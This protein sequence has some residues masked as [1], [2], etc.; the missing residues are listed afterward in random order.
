MTQPKWRTDCQ[1]WWERL[2]E[3]RSIVPPPIFPEEAARALEVFD[4]LKIVDAPGS[5]T[6]GEAAMP[7]VRDIVASIFGSYD[8]STGRRLIKE[9]LLVVPK[10]SSKSTIAS[11]IMMTALILNERLSAEGTIIAPTVEVATNAFKPAKDMVAHD[12]DLTEMMT[13][14]HHL[15]LITNKD[16]GAQLK[17]VAASADTLGGKKSSYILIDE[18]WLMGKMNDAV[19]MFSEA[20]G[21]LASRP[22]GFVVYLTTQS[23][24]PPAGVFKQKLEYARGVRDGTVDDPQFVPIIYEFPNDFISAGKHLDPA[25]FKI[26]NPNYGVSVDQDFLEREFR[27]AKEAGPDVLKV[28]TAK[29]LNV[30]VG[31]RLRANRWLGADFWLQTESQSVTLDSILERSEVVTV[32]GD[33]GGLD[34][35]LGLTLCGRDRDTKKK[36]IWSHAWAHPSVL[37][38]H[39]QFEAQIRDYAKRGEVTLV[40]RVG[41]DVLEFAAIVKRVF[42]AG[43]LYKVGLDPAGVG[44][45]LE[46]LSDAEI[47]EDQITGVSQGWRLG[48]AIKTAERWLAAGEIEHARQPLMNWCVGNAMVEPKGNAILITKAAS[49]GAK[50]DPVMSM[51]NSIE[52]MAH[53]PAAA[54]SRDMEEFFRNPIIAL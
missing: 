12:E 44:A 42:D 9:W 47:P 39:K 8:R 17:I 46:A 20:M 29:H 26:V 6:F 4:S 54:Q 16:T 36:L 31:M 51:L 7:W 30:E 53:N 45:I 11:A 43:L 34:D 5:P 27:K 49:G 32:G 52:L 18:L 23:D 40:D 2:Q 41:D 33:G 24:E 25:N 35:L 3:G 15:R 28:F 14:Q 48:A 10:K 19:N 50:I 38:R 22:E 21:G 1:D 37:E 13:V